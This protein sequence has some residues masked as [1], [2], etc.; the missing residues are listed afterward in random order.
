M[1]RRLSGAERPPFAGLLPG[2]TQALVDNLALPVE[3]KATPEETLKTMASEV[4]RLL[5]R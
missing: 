2:V 5:P 3:Q 4:Q 1:M